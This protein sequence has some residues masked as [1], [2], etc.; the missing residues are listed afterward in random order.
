MIDNYVSSEAAGAK[1]SIGL[2]FALLDSNQDADARIK[3]NVEVNQRTDLANSFD[4]DTERELY[5]RVDA[6]INGGLTLGLR[7]ISVSSNAVSKAVD[8]VG[9][10]TSTSS[11]T[12]LKTI[13][14]P[15]CIRQFKWFWGE[16]L[17]VT[18]R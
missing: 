9:M 11:N 5:D 7:D 17:S 15:R 1:V 14:A 18:S 6:I 3:G 4:V 10:L 16:C 2:N 13:Y 12:Y 8:Y